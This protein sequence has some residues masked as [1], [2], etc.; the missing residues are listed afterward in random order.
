MGGVDV[1]EDLRVTRPAAVEDQQ[2][3][4][5]AVGA[6]VGQDD[7]GPEL[8]R[9]DQGRPAGLKRPFG[10]GGLDRRDV[11]DRQAMGLQEAMPVDLDPEPAQLR[12]DAARG[13]LQ[14]P[15]DEDGNRGWFAAGEL[16]GLELGQGGYA[17]AFGLDGRG[18][19]QRRPAERER[20]DQG[21]C[22]RSSRWSDSR[23]QCLA[24][25]RCL[26]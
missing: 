14:V 17:Q 6:L 19:G 10:G 2:A 9:A 21:G 25:P 22:P 8:A 20:Q 23:A 12:R 3:S 26:P 5:G 7:A 1:G 16:V 18:W 4:L 11:A 13:A 24:R 15:G